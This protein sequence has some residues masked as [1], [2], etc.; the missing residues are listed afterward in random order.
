MSLEQEY[1]NIDFPQFS[2]IK[3]NLREKL[4]HIRNQKKKIGNIKPFGGIKQEL[5]WEQLDYMVAAGE[6]MI[7]PDEDEN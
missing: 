6:N 3:E 2:N 5:N 1:K 7:K 4:H